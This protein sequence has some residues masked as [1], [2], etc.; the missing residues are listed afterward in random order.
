MIRKLLLPLLVLLVIGLIGC[1]EEQ[2]TKSSADGT[3]DLNAEFGGFTASSETPGFGDDDLVEDA[4]GEVEYNDPL[5]QSPALDSLTGDPDAGVFHFRAVWGQ[6]DYDSTVSAVTDWAGS[7][8]ISR[9]GIAVRRLIRF[10]EANDYLVERSDRALVEWVSM[11]TVHNDGIAL[12]L[13]VPR[14]MPAIDT[15]EIPIVDTLG[16]T[17]W[18][19]T[20]DTIMPEPVEVE[21]TTGPYSRTFTLGELVALDTIVYLDDADSNAVA[22]HAFKLDRTPCG[23]GFLAGHWGRDEEGRGIFRGMWMSRHGYIDGWLQGRYGQNDQGRKVFFGKWID[24]SGNFEGFLRGTYNT[25][26]NAHA[27]GN[28]FRHAGGW[29]AGNIYAADREE[30][31]LLKGRFKGPHG[32]NDVG[33][34]QGLWRLHCDNRPMGDGW[35]NDYDD[36]GW[37]DDE[38]DEWGDDDDD[39]DDDDADDDDDGGDDS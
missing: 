26:P 18:E 36:D 20:V 23:S 21:F 25:R 6:L 13:F 1:S 12:D 14:P 9:G 19:T 34:F 11:T 39:A 24:D 30:I 32:M 16:D 5:L 31:G 27:N 28:A 8:T 37:D 3:Y 33:Y 29:F 38:E 10:E 35:D 17:T 4:E 2:A 22:F 7:L 15:L